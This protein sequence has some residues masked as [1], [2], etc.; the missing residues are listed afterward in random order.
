VTIAPQSPQ[1]DEM[2]VYRCASCGRIIFK[3]RLP[4]GSIVETKCK[5]NTIASIA[6][7]AQDRAT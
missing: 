7:T 3:A 6:V 4:A 2:R 5:C 1:V